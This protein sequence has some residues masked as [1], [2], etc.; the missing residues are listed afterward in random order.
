MYAII[1]KREFYG[2]RTVRQ[3]L[4]DPTTRWP[5]TFADQEAARA[6]VKELDS[7]VYYLSHNESDRPTYTVHRVDRLA[8]RFREEIAG[9]A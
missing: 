8:R 5:E 2:P 9:T 4:A 3:L 6:Q 7:A 1:A